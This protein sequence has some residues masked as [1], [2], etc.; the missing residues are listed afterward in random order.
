MADH[1]RSASCGLNSV[2][3]PLV[4]RLN[5]SG[6]I[7]MYTFWRFGLKLMPIFEEFLGHISPYDVTHRPDPQ[8]DRHIF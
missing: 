2:L 4:R 5:S 1:P 8:K 7:V 3:K 6:D